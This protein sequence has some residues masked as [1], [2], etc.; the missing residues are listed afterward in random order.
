ME[1]VFEKLYADGGLGFLPLA[2]FCLQ[3]PKL[4]FRQKPSG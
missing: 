1:S 3:I 4:S 2:R